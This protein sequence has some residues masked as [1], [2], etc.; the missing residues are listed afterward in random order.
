MSITKKCKIELIKK[1][2]TVTNDTGSVEVQCAILT[3]RIKNLTIHLKHNHKDYSSR[4]GLLM[5]V[6]RRR[7]FL[8]YLKN[9]NLNRY[10]ILINKLGLRK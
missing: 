1:Y 10:V 6:G 5:I 3:E 2:A 7:R 4:R 9:Q 8:T